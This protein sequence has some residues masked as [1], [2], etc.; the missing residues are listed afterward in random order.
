MEDFSLFPQQATCTENLGIPKQYSV[1]KAARE[2][3]KQCFILKLATCFSIVELFINTHTMYLQCCKGGSTSNSKTESKILYLH[4][5]ISYLV[6][7]NI[8]VH[9]HV[10]SIMSEY[11]LYSHVNEI[12]PVNN[13]TSIVFIST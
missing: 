5:N 12:I 7:V 1:L 11:F 6:N 2:N 3:Q 8:P 9:V 10:S 4:L 13:Y